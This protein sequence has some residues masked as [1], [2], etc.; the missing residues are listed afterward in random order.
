MLNL[1]VWLS[2]AVL[3]WCRSVGRGGWIGVKDSSQAHSPARGA[4][5]GSTMPNRPNTT[6]RRH[7]ELNT[8]KGEHSFVAAAV[9][10]VV[11]DDDDHDDDDVTLR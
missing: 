5:T 6:A 9:V 1:L 3:S 7:A 8:C 10:A 11:V 4:T 2:C